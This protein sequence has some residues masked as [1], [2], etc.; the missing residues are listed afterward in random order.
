MYIRIL[1]GFSHPFAKLH[2]SYLSTAIIVKLAGK[3]GNQGAVLELHMRLVVRLIQTIVIK[4]G[5]HQEL[6]K[7]LHRIGYR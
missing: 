1:P 7:G 4:G 6:H 3:I 2:L 5:L